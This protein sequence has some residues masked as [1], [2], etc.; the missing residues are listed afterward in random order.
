MKRCNDIEDGIDAIRLKLR[1]E[2]RGVTLKE[3]TAYIK[4]QV[5]PV[6]KEFGIRTASEI[7]TDKLISV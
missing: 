3:E 1:E 6:L 7:K 4:S 2:L 5:G